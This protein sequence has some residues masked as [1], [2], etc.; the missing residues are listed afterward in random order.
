MVNN[1]QRCVGCPFQSRLQSLFFLGGK[2]AQHPIRQIKIRMGL[3]AHTDLYPGEIL[4]A[5]LGNDG[6]D[7]VMAAGRTVGADSSRC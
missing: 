3:G 4:I 2:C 6:F 5:Q 1:G 7:A